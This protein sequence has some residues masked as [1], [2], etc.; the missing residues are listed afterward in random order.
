MSRRSLEGLLL[1]A[2]VPGEASLQGSEPVVRAV[3]LGDGWD[4]VGGHAHAH[5]VS[6]GQF[7]ALLAV[8]ADPGGTAGVPRDL[9]VKL[10]IV[11]EDDRPVQNGEGFVGGGSRGG[12]GRGLEGG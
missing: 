12:G 8:E 2:V 11:W 4:G 7:L 5:H 9:A 6:L 10:R 1:H 3:G